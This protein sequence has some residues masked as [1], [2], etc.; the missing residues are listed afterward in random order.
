MYFGVTR[1]AATCNQEIFPA[2]WHQ[3]PV[4]QAETVAF[5]EAVES[6]EI[7]KEALELLSDVS[8]G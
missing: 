8:V 7:G 3:D 1:V 2:L 6:F 5:A 4:G